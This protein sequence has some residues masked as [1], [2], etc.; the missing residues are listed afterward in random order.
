[1]SWLASR[2]LIIRFFCTEYAVIS[3]PVVDLSDGLP[4]FKGCVSFALSIQLSV[5]QSLI[6]WVNHHSRDTFLL[7]WVCSRQSPSRWPIGH[8]T[9]IQEMHLFCT[10]Y[11]VVGLVI[12][13]LDGMLFFPY[14]AYTVFSL[15]TAQNYLRNSSILATFISLS[16]SSSNPQ[17]VGIFGQ[18]FRPFLSSRRGHIGPRSRSLRHQNSFT[19]TL[20]IRCI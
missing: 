5:S 20:E 2:H 14:T 18:L 17:G 15:T 4:S 6:Y 16:I 8:S 9:I 10:E 11:P 3:F 19:R 7:H 13:L 1:M 12:S